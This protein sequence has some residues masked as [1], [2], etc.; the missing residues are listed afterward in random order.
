MGPSLATA[1]GSAYPIDRR[2]LPQGAI[3]HGHYEV[4]FAQN[5][6]QLDEILQL[7]FQVFNM[8]LGEGLDASHETGRDLDEFDPQCH[9]LYVRDTRHDSIVGTYRVQTDTMAQAGRGFYSADE[10]DLSAFPAGIVNDAVE[11]GRACIDRDHRN[12]SVLFLLWRGLASYTSMSSKRYLFGCCSLTSQDPREGW[13]MYR[14]LGAAGHLH[15]ALC[16]P[17]TPAYSCRG[18]AQNAPAPGVKLP[19][20]FRTYLRFG[21]TVCSEPAIDRRF[22]TIDFLVLF[23]LAAM[24]PRSRSLFFG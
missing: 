1:L 9:H 13:G 18:A 11:V 16:L 5:L 22:K 2:L 10:Y 21:A 8:E 15:P 6:G 12:Q 19:K 3:H 17:A 14:Q 20:L 24:D 4:G 23:D 7:R